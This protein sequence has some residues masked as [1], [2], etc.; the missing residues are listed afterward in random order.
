MM[1]L[2]PSFNKQLVQ[3]ERGDGGVHEG[4]GEEKLF[5]L[6]QRNIDEEIFIHIAKALS[7]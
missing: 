5:L 2:F 7:A 3:I 4:A 1:A 6:L